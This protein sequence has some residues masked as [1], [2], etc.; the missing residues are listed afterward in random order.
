MPVVLPAPAPTHTATYSS[1]FNEQQNTINEGLEAIRENRTSQPLWNTIKSVFWFTGYSVSQAV[2]AVGYFA[3]HAVTAM[4]TPFAAVVGAVYA[5]GQSLYH[6]ATGKAPDKTFLDYVV[7]TVQVASKMTYNTVTDVLCRYII[8]PALL[9]S[10][11]EPAVCLAA[12]GVVTLLASP[13]IYND[14]K[15]NEGKTLRWLSGSS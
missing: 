11:V 4:I 2:Q 5:S 8:G 9:F 3:G 7:S 1:A 12:S 10:F 15:N 13:F 14:L 6:H